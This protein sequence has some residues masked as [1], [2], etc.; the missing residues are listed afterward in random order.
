MQ[1]RLRIKEHMRILEVFDPAM[2][3]FDPVH[4]QFAADLKWVEKYGVKVSR[5]NL[6]Q[7]PKAFAANPLVTREMESGIDRLPVIMVDGHVI[8][9][10]MY[11]SRQQLAQE[12]GIPA[13]PEEM[14]ES[15]G[16]CCSPKPGFR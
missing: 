9:A 3:Y 1:R 8:S 6:S 5:H 15:A 4:V 10:G 2:R 16:C 14:F 13:T 11:P 12:L 7:E